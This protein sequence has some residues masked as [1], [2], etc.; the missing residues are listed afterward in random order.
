MRG[1]LF[2]YAV[3]YHS[4]IQ[5]QKAL[6]ALADTEIE[7][8]KSVLLVEPKAVVALSED[9]VRTLAGREIPEEYTSKLDQVEILVRPFAP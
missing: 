7:T 8:A 4:K 1:Q 3:L 9:E 6:E 2:E 5:P